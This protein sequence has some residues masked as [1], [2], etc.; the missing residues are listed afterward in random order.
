MRVAME[1][2][3]IPVHRPFW[4]TYGVLNTTIKI[5]KHDIITI[6]I[7]AINRSC[8]IWGQDAHIFRYANTLVCWPWP[9]LISGAFAGLRDPPESS[10]AIQGLYSN[11]LTFLSGNRGCIGYR[12][13]LVE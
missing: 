7:Q 9:H 11:I 8:S 10:K 4:D 12:F 2:D 1:D 13:A 6:P 5:A 3:K